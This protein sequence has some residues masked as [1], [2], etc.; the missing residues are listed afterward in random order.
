M[1]QRRLAAKR[2]NLRHWEEQLALAKKERNAEKE[3]Q[4]QLNKNKIII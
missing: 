1:E 2:D 4:L 3:A